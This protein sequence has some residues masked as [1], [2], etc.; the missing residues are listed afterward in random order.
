[1]ISQRA[2]RAFGIIRMAQLERR[3]CGS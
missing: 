3:Y 1:L 2:F